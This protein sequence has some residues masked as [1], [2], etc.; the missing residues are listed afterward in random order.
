MHQ[1]RSF[2][3]QNLMRGKDWLPGYLSLPKV[4][5]VEMMLLAATSF[6]QKLRIQ[7]FFIWK[8]YVLWVIWLKM[9]GFLVA[10][11]VHVRRDLLWIRLVVIGVTRDLKLLVYEIIIGVELVLFN[12]DVA[13]LW[14]FFEVDLRICAVKSYL[15]FDFSLLIWRVLHISLFKVLMDRSIKFSIY[16]IV[17]RGFTHLIVQVKPKL[18]LR[19]RLL[20]TL[21]SRDMR[22]I[23]QNPSLLR[24]L[25]VWELNFN[26]V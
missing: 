2:L 18:F 6:Y 4:D 7:P 25:T 19:I 21:V 13:F 16:R 23:R 11:R 22:R 15:D 14:I 1:L 9:V 5:H 26:I 10:H 12:S 3:S 8:S 20:Q 24:G 17:W